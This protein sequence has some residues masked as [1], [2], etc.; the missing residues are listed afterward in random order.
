[1]F[2]AQI[3]YGKANKNYSHD[4]PCG[5]MNEETGEGETSL[6]QNAG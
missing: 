4:T 2:C 6:V 1:M 3:G 5:V